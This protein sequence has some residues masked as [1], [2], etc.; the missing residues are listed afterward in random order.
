MKNPTRFLKTTDRS[1]MFYWQ[2]DRPFNEKEIKEIFLERHK[3]FDT[4]QAKEA[5]EYGMRAYYGK[6]KK[7]AV[8]AKMDN[9]I[10]F[11][12]VNVVLKATLKDDTDL[13]IRIH[14][15]GIKNGYFWAESLAS[16]TA[17]KHGIPTYKTYF[18][19]DS[20][21]KFNFDYMI[22]ECL[23]GENIQKQWPLDK[24]KE[25]KLIEET[26]YFLAKIHT[27]KTKNFGFFDNNIAKDKNALVGI[28]GRWK[29]HIYAALVDNLNYLI[30]NKT[31]TW[32]ER[33][34]I[35]KIFAKNSRLLEFNTPRLIQNDL[36]DWNQLS[37]ADNVT[38]IIDWDECY[39]GDPVA[40][41]SAWSVFFPFE[42]MEYL[43]KGYLK[44][45][46]LPEG[47]EEKLHFY[48]IRYI[49]S[50]ATLRTKK[51]LFYKDEKI[52]KML[53]YALRILQDEFK[54]YGL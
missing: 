8:V 23:P 24:E 18:I 5:I 21:K 12:S 9:V 31:I 36:A 52:Q 14:P 25:K 4:T 1:N 40:D 20:Q 41:F 15:P 33:I 39:S 6:T 7:D 46:S 34:K 30:K 37:N 42:R 2:T 11:G 54:W 44:F 50:K 29:D 38:G 16:V 10:A 27:I 19:D 32:E 49:V 48:R 45:S 51:L 17:K 13:I 26:G 35:E 3:N 53:D 28:H 43:K 47:F 22:V